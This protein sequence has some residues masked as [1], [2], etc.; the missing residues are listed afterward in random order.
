MRVMDFLNWD[1][2]FYWK[3]RQRIPFGKSIPTVNLH[4]ERALPTKITFE[5]DALRMTKI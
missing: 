1:L 5:H 2:F 4:I 3:I